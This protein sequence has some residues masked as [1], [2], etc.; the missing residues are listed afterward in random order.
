MR[1]RS[2]KQVKIIPWNSSV[3]SAVNGVSGELETPWDCAKIF[4][5]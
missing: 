5:N 3:K 1:G 4:G 2:I